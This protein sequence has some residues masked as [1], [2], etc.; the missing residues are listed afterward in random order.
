L[1]SIFIKTT[2]AAYQLKSNKVPVASINLADELAIL[3]IGLFVNNEHFANTVTVGTK[4]S[5]ACGRSANA[6]AACAGIR[7]NLAKAIIRVYKNEINGRN[8]EHLM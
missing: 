3:L 2:E 6:N 1:T 7:S 4:D 5:V 8:F